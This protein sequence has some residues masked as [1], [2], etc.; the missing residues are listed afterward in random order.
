VESKE[1][2]ASFIFSFK[3]NDLVIISTE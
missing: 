1:L 3:G 2:D